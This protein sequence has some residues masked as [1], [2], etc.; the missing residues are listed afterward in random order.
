MGM[1]ITMRISGINNDV[2]VKLPI[3]VDRKEAIEIAK[4]TVRTI[5]DS[6]IKV[7]SALTTY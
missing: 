3:I 5:K 6:D 2:I 7:K 1:E 4:K